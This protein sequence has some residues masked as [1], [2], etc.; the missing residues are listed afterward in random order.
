[1]ESMTTLHTQT[2]AASLR[3]RAT[4]MF[5]MVAQSSLAVL[6]TWMRRANTRRDLM[7]LDAR[8]LKDIGIDPGHAEKE[9]VKPF[10][11]A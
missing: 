9:A 4:T 2:M 10:W 3:P 6:R 8:L 7:D 1:M 5:G 11:A